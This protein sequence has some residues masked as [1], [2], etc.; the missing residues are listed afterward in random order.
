MPASWHASHGDVPLSCLLSV[1]LF[2]TDLLWRSKDQEALRR[3][4]DHHVHHGIYVWVQITNTTPIKSHDH[5]HN[6]RGRTP[7]AL[8]WRDSVSVSP[9]GRSPC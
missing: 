3:D 5:V 7:H 9:S 4:H 2:E 1:G 8:S 6:A